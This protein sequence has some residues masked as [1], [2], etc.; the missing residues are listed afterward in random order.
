MGEKKMVRI[1]NKLITLK[2]VDCTIHES[3]TGR[4]FIR[5]KLSGA[6]PAT[7]I[8]AYAVGLF[9]PGGKILISC[10]ISIDDVIEGEDGQRPNIANKVIGKEVTVELGQEIFNGFTQTLVKNVVL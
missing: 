7:D 4:G 10:G 1:D 8:F 2:I 9:G 3:K 5:L 6:P